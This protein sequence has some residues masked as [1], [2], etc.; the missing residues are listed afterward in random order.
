MFFGLS[1]RQ[2]VFSVLGCLVAAGLFI[3]LKPIFGIETASWICIIGAFPFALLG[4]LTYNKMPAER[5]LIV[6][7]K[8]EFIL[9]KKLAFGNTNIYS[10]LLDEVKKEKLKTRFHIASRKEIKR[11][12]NYKKHNK[13]I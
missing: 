12:K 1:L 5:F 3:I 7:F 9:P 13:K 10:R 4:F 11:E 6:W 8:N 2:F